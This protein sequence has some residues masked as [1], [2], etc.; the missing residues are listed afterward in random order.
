MN[1]EQGVPIPPSHS[2]MVRYPFAEMKVGESFT[3]PKGQQRKLRVAASHFK[4]RNPGWDYVT[5][6]EGDQVRLW[7]ITVPTPEKRTDAAAR[8]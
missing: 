3:L 5:R 7:R 8:R 4:G 6:I 1:I 2:S